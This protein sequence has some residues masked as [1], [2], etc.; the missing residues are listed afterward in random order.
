MVLFIGHSSAVRL[1]RSLEDFEGIRAARA[2]PSS[3]DIPALPKSFKES[4][5]LA[6]LPRPL[7]VVVSSGKTR[8]QAKQFHNNIWKLPDR[9]SCFLLFENGIYLSNPEF[10]FVQLARSCSVIDLIKLGFEL[11]GT[12]RMDSSSPIG[13]QSAR[14]LSS[15]E[16]ISR[17]IDKM[18]GKAPRKAKTAVRYVRSGS[19]SPMETCLALL[20]GLP[21]SYGGY[22]LGMP[23]MNAKVL[24]PAKYGKRATYREY[25]CDLYWPEQNVAI[26]YN[27]REF[28]VNELAVER[29]AS[30]I[31]N[32]KAAGIEV[33]AVTRAHVADN[34]KFDAI[35]HS[36][37]SL[38]GKRI[39]VAYAD[40]DER[41]ADLRKQLFSKD[42]WC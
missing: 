18:P 38:M 7:E 37:A 30:R 40:I 39:R 32:L 35:A 15:P 2:M 1:L 27:S 26:E 29:D 33:L 17:F 31:N 14:P 10:C 19:A 9:T 25:H 4:S 28:H 8:S 13:F 23:E 22:G 12:Y 36:A 3:R 24:I 41:R 20:L 16:A 34:K 5:P 11:C 6:T 21:A 42:P